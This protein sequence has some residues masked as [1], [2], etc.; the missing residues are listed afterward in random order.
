MGGRAGGGARGGGLSRGQRTS[1]KW[2]KE[3]GW[4][5]SEIAKA[6]EGMIAKNNAKLAESLKPKIK[7]AH[8]SYKKAQAEYNAAG[9][10]LNNYAKG[11]T[12]GGKPQGD[13]QKISARFKKASDRYDRA[14]R[15]WSK[16]KQQKT[17]A[18]YKAGNK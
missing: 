14:H 15:K 9:Q 10:A 1:L 3:D 18:D 8:E 7:A 16:L 13:Y 17:I 4:S 12:P 11:I 5:A 2:L 6:K